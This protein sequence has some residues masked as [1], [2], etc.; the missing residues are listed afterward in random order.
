[1]LECLGVVA[2]MPAGSGREDGFR[3]LRPMPMPR[4]D[5]QSVVH[6]R[7]ALFR[8]TFAPSSE[9]FIFDEIRSHDRYKVDVFAQ[10]RANESAFPWPT[11]QVMLVPRRE[12]LRYVLTNHSTTFLQLM[13]KR[14]YA[15]VHGHFGPQAVRASY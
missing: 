9:T 14:A 3:A 11:D 7:V 15:V 6:P 4:R 10:K 8:S 1:M 5:D 13:A 2:T 12:Y